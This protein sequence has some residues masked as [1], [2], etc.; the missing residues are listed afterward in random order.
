MSTSDPSVMAD[1]TLAILA[2]GESS[3]MGTPK[4]SLLIRGQPILEH[5]LDQIAWPGKTMLV[6]APGREHPPGSGRF[7]LEVQDPPGGGGP[8]RGILTALE[9]LQTP[10]LVVMPVDMPEIRKAH[11]Q[12]LVNELMKREKCLGLFMRR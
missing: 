3:R 11:L 9:H 4:A 10:V 7:D 5:L 12:F 6:T 1:A 8:L 2:G